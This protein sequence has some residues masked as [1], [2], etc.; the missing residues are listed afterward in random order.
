MESTHRNVAGVN[1]NTV[2]DQV[3]PT[4]NSA[5]PEFGFHPRHYDDGGGP[6]HDNNERAN[7]NLGPAGLSRS[8]L[9]DLVRDQ[10]RDRAESSGTRRT[11][12]TP[13][14]CNVRRTDDTL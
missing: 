6:S 12:L 9:T 1:R 5:S 14:H 8:W 7:P 11:T 2:A 13:P 10:V 3:N 4:V